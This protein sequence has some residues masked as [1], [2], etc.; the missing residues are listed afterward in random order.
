MVS[1]YYSKDKRTIGY[2]YTGEIHKIL[3]EKKILI[4]LELNPPSIVSIVLS[5]PSSVSTGC[6]DRILR[7]TG[8]FHTPSLVTWTSICRLLFPNSNNASCDSFKKKKK[9]KAYPE[10]RQYKQYKKSFCPFNISECL[11]KD[12]YLGFPKN[13]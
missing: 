6:W 13:K 7:R 3:T 5:L 1:F 8:F 12:L 2:R 11:W 9:K 4:P 10:N